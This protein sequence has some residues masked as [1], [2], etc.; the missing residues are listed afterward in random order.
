M[1]GQKFN[2]VLIDDE[3]DFLK[4]YKDHLE[5][6]FHVHPFTNPRSALSFIES[7]NVDAIV[8]DYHMPGSSANDVFMELRM[9]KF[10]QPILFLT[11]ESNVAVKLN[12]LDLGV[13]DFLSKPISTVELKAYL[14]NRIKAYKRRNPGYITVKNISFR[15]SDPNVILNNEVVALSPKEFEIFSMLVEKLNTVVKKTDILANVWGSVKVE[16]N[17]VDTH[18]SNLRKKLIGFTGEIK[19]VKCIGYI[20]KA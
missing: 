20:L 6:E 7:F 4:S 5:E 18:M 3:A 1:L 12:S 14:N 16:E 13:D 2:V 9:K 15:V 17:N 10:D 19:T 11:G 8:M